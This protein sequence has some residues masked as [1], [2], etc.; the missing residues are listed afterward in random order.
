MSEHLSNSF[1]IFTTNSDTIVATGQ[2]DLQTDA[3]PLVGLVTKMKTRNEATAI[4][5]LPRILL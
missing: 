5:L 4:Q 2:S 1:L 3:L